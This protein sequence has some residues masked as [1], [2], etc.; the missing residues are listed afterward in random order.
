MIRIVVCL[1][2]DAEDPYQAY[3]IL[4]RKMPALAPEIDYETTDEWYFEDGESVGD[5][6]QVR[7][8]IFR[9]EGLHD[10]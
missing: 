6:S 10:E 9:E 2:I 1:D 5:P 8:S 3:R 4:R 7:M